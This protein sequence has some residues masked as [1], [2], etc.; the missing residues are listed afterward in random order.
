MKLLT[1]R[2]MKAIDEIAIH[3]LGIPGIVLMENAAIQVAFKASSMLEGKEEPNITVIAGRG[4][5]GGDALAVTRH[6]LTMGY[7]VSVFSLTDVDEL[8]GDAFINGRI[9]KNLGVNI[10]VI[11]GEESLERLKLACR[12]S[13]LVIEG[14]FGTGLNRNVQGIVSDII[15]IINDFAPKVLSID[16]PSGID[17]LSGK[18]MGNCI[19]ADATVTFYLP[20]VGMVQHPGASFIGELSVVDIGIPYALSEQ[21]DT[22]LLTEQDDVKRM[23]P[24]R[25]ADGHKGTFGKLLML[26]GSESMTGAA[27]LSAFSAY[28]AGSGL[29]RLAA[30][31]ACI[32]TL[33]ILLPEAVCIGLT[34]YGNTGSNNHIKSLIDDSDAVLIGPGLSCSDEALNLLETVIEYCDKPMV[35]DADALNLL[36]KKKSLLE[37]LRCETVI[38]PHPA[39]M[40]RLAGKPVTRIQEDRINIAR[41]FADEFGLTVVLKGAGTIIAA[42][43]GRI[44][45]NPTGNH[46]M[47]TAGSGD[48]LAGVITSLLGQGLSPYEAAIAGTYL[49]GL[50]GDF[51]AS[52]KGAVGVM[53]SDIAENIPKAFIHI[54]S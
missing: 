36:S 20:K 28:K 12:D 29:V 2:Q 47:A 21:L 37:D 53:A 33:S 18:V 44:S 26:A 3:T 52:E 46:G 1:P 23:L 6:L 16:I 40:S 17:G 50:A 11:S 54:Q 45:I 51:A 27:Y 10:P 15:D 42:N 7:S 48:V 41:S 31:R 24:I 32:N 34:G 5:N 4:N 22:P 8:S 39:E 13:D 43:D 35:M 49:H 14:I 9:L 25:P 19:K 38:T 30:P